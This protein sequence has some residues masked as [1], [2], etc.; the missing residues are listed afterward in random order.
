MSLCCSS[1]VASTSLAYGE[2]SNP[3][4]PMGEQPGPSGYQRGTGSLRDQEPGPSGYPSG[5][6]PTSNQNSG[7]ASRSG[8]SRHQE[9]VPSGY[10][11]GQDD[12]PNRYQHVMTSSSRVTVQGSIEYPANS[13]DCQQPVPSGYVPVGRSSSDRDQDYLP[14]DPEPGPSGYHPLDVDESVEEESVYLQVVSESF[15][16]EPGPS[17]YRSFGGSTGDQESGFQP[18]GSA[19]QDQEPGPSG[20][21]SLE[22]AYQEPAE[23]NDEPSGGYQKP[24]RGLLL[25]N[26]PGPSGFKVNRGLSQAQHSGAVRHHNSGGASNDPEPGPS[27][28]PD[29]AFHES[30]PGPSLL[31]LV[32]GEISNPPSPLGGQAVPVDSDDDDESDIESPQA[33][34][35]GGYFGAAFL[36]DPISN[37]SSPQAGPSAAPAKRRNI[38]PDSFAYNNKRS[39]FEPSPG[40]SHAFVQRNRNHLN[41]SR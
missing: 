36:P 19:S 24:V 7:Y 32:H 30:H 5:R 4:S 41:V 16:Q 14:G 6:G 9:P 35:S 22:R 38:P 20:Y 29:L 40:R 13:H 34:P 25:D 23:E 10:P 8:M 28:Y 11:S 33:G 18:V 21:E 37:P 39:R 31:G 3:A 26:E 17:G 1:H 12:V 15:D 27:D 2:V